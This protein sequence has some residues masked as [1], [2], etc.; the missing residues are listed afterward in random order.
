MQQRV[1]LGCWI[2]GARLHTG[3]S[4]NLQINFNNKK[5][6]KKYIK[7]KQMNSLEQTFC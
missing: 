4:Q 7:L 2:I 5:N 1:D 6:E 3:N